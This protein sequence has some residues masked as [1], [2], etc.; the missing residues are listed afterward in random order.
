MN[1]DIRYPQAPGW[2]GLNQ[3][4]RESSRIAAETVASK[5]ATLRER[6]YQAL[7]ELGDMTAD[8]VAEVL[9]HPP[10]STRPRI[11][12]LH[13]QGRIWPTNLRRLSAGGGTATVW[14]VRRP[15]VAIEEVAHG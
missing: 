8:E 3:I 1:A 5:A 15:D 13:R 6:A 7:V 4:S 11:A 2:S 14:T 12:E 9:Q 10:L